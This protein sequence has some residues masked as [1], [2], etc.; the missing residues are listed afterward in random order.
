MIQSPVEP[1]LPGP[2]LR[3]VEIPVCCIITF[4][5]GIHVQRITNGVSTIL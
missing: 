1:M 4:L 2:R 3:R 5:S